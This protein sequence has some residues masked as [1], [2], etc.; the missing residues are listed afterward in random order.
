[1]ESEKAPEISAWEAMTVARVASVL[2]IPL[3]SVFTN[4]TLA[5]DKVLRFCVNAG[6]FVDRT[7]HRL[8]GKWAESLQSQVAAGLADYPIVDDR[9]RRCELTAGYTSGQARSHTAMTSSR[10]S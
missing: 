5:D 6:S 3:D 1:M 7:G 8:L 9:Y 4:R 10:T 2:G